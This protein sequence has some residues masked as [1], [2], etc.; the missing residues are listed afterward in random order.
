MLLDK[1]QEVTDDRHGRTGEEDE[2][3]HREKVQEDGVAGALGRR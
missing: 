1:R 2:G 3:L